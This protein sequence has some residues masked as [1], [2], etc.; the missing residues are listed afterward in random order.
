MKQ[1]LKTKHD[2]QTHL[3]KSLGNY[4]LI[5]VVDFLITFQEFDYNP[6]EIAKN[7]NVSFVTF[8]E[9][10]PRLVE[11]GIVKKTR[12]VGNAT[13]YKLDKANIVVKKLLELDNALRANYRQII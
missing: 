12:N 2:E 3:V 7:S 6:T 1:Q 9:F 10:W 5:R 11:Q 8:Q 4:P 13:M